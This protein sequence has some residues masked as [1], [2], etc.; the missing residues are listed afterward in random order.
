MNI[1][2]LNADD[3]DVVF[4]CPICDSDNQIIQNVQTEIVS[5]PYQASWHGSG[6]LLKVIIKCLGCTKDYELCIGV[7]KN[8]IY[9]FVRDV[10]VHKKIVKF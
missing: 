5:K 6:N 1:L 10:Q 7:H 8:K 9:R 3:F 2:K 4:K